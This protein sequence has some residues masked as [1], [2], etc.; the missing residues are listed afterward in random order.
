[1]NQRYE[2]N[3][4]P[5]EIEVLTKAF[6]RV[7]EQWGLN[8][9]ELAAIIGVSPSVI[10]RVK[11]NKSNAIAPHTMAGKMALLFIRVYRGLSAF[12]GDKMGQQKNWLHAYNRAFNSSPLE[13]MHRPEGLLHVVLY[14]DAM[15]GSQ[16]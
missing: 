15:R 5:D 7:G 9:Q 6:L 10:T 2:N 3:K 1:M 11:Q 8:N 14:L 13:A 4:Q 12:L 16:G